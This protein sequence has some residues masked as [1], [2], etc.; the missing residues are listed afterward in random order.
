[1]SGPTR[2]ALPIILIRGFGGFDTAD[3]RKNAYQGFT[4]GTV[5]PQK[6]GENYIYEG[7]L[8]RFMKSNWKYED[9]TNVV[10]YY[11]KKIERE[12][13]LPEK[14]KR[15]K[16]KD[17]VEKF[18]RLKDMGY[19]EGDKIIID[20]GMA[21]HLLESTDDP[22]RSIWIFRY[23]DLDDR[24]YETYGKALVRL[25]DF[26]GEITAIKT[27][28][29]PLVNIIAHSMGGLL[30][31]EAVQNTYPKQERKAEDYINKIVTLGTPHQGVT[32]QILKHWLNISAADDM[33]HFNPEF[34]ADE[35]NGISYKNFHKHFPL[36]RLLTIVGTNYRSY[37]NPI[38][39]RLNRLFS[40]EGEL[41]TSY[42]RS[43][44]LVK[45]IAAQI[46]G[47][48]RTFIHKCHGGPDSILTSRE[49][50]EI[51][52]RFFFGNVLI[53]LRLAKGKITRGKD[54]FGK[55]EFY[56]GVS[57]KPR[58]VDFELFHQSKEGENCY[59][60]FSKVDPIDNNVDFREE[61]NELAFAW[62]D[63]NKLIWEG[64]LNTIP[65]IEDNS[66][67]T[68]DMVMR[69]DFYVSERDLFGIGFSDNRV[70]NKQYYVRALLPTENQPNLIL[71]LHTNERF[72]APDFQPSDTEKMRYIAGGWEFDV[73]GTDFAG[74]FRIEIDEVPEVGELQAFMRN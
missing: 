56:L 31:Q 17:I 53:R 45:H 65:I 59:G 35:N 25:I 7:L 51:A 69:L 18:M 23:Y 10:G 54:F 57:I 29:K 22:W 73:S 67:T 74:T 72:A 37:N 62:E 34:M 4:D 12:P 13:L 46:P 24:I 48:A 52:T 49:T 60:P 42:N 39:S 50:F 43:D 71:Y 32:F 63:D 21:L 1:M 66:I 41:G 30:V 28:A 44:G 26:I 40:L 11:S 8:L 3:E 61:N 36:K 27:G 14:L 6:Q 15:T 38:S 9:A 47:S 55:S 16:D 2:R 5:Y 33:K 58:G 19:F 70:F 20:P 68:K 64:Y